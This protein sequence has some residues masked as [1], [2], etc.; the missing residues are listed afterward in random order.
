MTGPWPLII[1]REDTAQSNQLHRQLSARGRYSIG[2][3]LEITLEYGYIASHQLE[4]ISST[5]S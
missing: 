3:R 5:A 4:T 1:C 2:S